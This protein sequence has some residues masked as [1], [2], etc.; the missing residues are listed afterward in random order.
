MHLCEPYYP[1]LSGRRFHQASGIEVEVKY[2]GTSQLA[3]TILEEGNNSPADILFAQDPGG[4]GAVQDLLSVLPDEVLSEV[5]QWAG[6]P[7]GTWVGLSGRARTVVYNP[8]RV[9]EDELPDDIWGFVNPE[10]KD[11][12]GWAPTYASFQA[13]IT[14]MHTLWGE[15]KAKEW[16]LGVQANNPTIYPKNTPQV[17]AVA[18]GEIDVGLVNHY[19]LFRFL[20]EEGED[21]PARNY[22]PRAGGPGATIMVAGAGILETSEN[23]EAAVRFLEFMLS[24]VGQQYFAG[25]TFE[26]PLVDGVNV[27]HVLVPLEEIEHPSIPLKDLADLEGTQRLLRETGVLP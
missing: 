25:Q 6:S 18:A 27:P 24:Q 15:E 17:A 8:Q 9:S 16:L 21:F 20:A 3:A 7:D 12:I 26:Y 23:K 19:Y 5:P 10:W 2:A 1:S 4:L 14:A 11:R 13:M 22:H